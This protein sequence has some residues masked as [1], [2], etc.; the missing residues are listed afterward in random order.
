MSQGNLPQLVYVGRFEEIVERTSGAVAVDMPIGLPSG[1]R[2]VVRACDREARA[3][4]GPRRSSVFPAPTR[5]M[6]R[7]KSFEALRGSGLS[8]QSFHLFPKL[9]ELDAVVRASRST[10]QRLRECHPEL[11]F[12]DLAGAPLEANKR[13]PEGRAER[14]A[15]LSRAFG[16]PRAHLEVHVQTFCAEHPRGRLAPD[17]AVDALVLALLARDLEPE[18]RRVFRRMR[19]VIARGSRWR[20]GA[21]RRAARAGRGAGV[22]AG[23]A[24]RSE[25]TSGAP[26]SSR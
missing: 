22:R 20:S 3:L 16:V 10:A 9:R 5:G 1:S 13:S 8:L 19:S 18:R 6:L 7:A 2:S 23:R 21:L 4:L 17:D 15:L 12:R 26:G 24:D 25:W 11:A 14:Y